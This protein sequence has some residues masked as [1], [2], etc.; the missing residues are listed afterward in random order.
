MS[1]VEPPVKTP[2]TTQH[3]IRL[4]FIFLA[5]VF[6]LMGLI[7]GWFAVYDIS[8]LAQYGIIPIVSYC[9]FALIGFGGAIVFTV[10][11]RHKASVQGTPFGFQLFLVGGPAFVAAFV[12]G[13]VL[14]TWPS[15]DFNLTVIL[16][17]Y[18]A[19]YD[20]QNS[21]LIVSHLGAIRDFQHVPPEG[22]VTIA[23]IPRRF[24]NQKIPIELIS[25]SF[26]KRVPQDEY[27]IPITKVL[28]VEVERIPTLAEQR[29]DLKA[30]FSAIKLG[31]DETI[32]TEAEKLIPHLDDYIS[33]PTLQNWE[34]VTRDVEESLQNVKEGT[35]VSIEYNNFV[36][37]S[38]LLEV[39]GGTHDV[40]R[41]L[42]SL[43]DRYNVK[44]EL[45]VEIHGHQ[46]ALPTKDEADAWKKELVECIKKLSDRL[47]A[48]IKSF[49]DSPE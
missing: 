8:I 38:P 31:V 49:G 25:E 48:V 41:D 10:V 7:T 12:S 16:K 40:L 30:R 32:R 36:I 4:T 29:K 17:G 19:K 34:T 26:R 15:E 43:R 35:Q 33:K 24:L 37:Q 3:V 28:Y 11:V 2:H 13:S 5:V 22:D 27:G 46:G 45:Y 20:P 42:E 1:K 6:V 14:A 23:E 47:D 9:V 39:L 21:T 18:D 44:G